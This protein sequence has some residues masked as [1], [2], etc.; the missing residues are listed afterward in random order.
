MA[1]EVSATEKSLLKKILESYLSELRLEIVETKHD[2]SSL[3]E[4]ENMVK[5]LLEKVS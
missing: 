2:K 5:G 1:I 3:H 4:E